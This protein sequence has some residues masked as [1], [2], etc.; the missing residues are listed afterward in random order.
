[1]CLFSYLL[2]TGD[3]EILYSRCY[4]ANAKHMMFSLQFELIKNFL[5]PVLG[6][7]IID[8]SCG[9]G[10][11]SRIFA[12]SGLFSSIVAL[13]YSENMLKE[14]YEFIKQEENFPKE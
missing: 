13:D 5:T 9:S 10:M 12:K 11:F 14:C 4:I 6:G 2:H 1:M 7:N 8:A 3:I